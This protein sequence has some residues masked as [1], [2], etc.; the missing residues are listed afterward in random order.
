MIEVFAGIGKEKLTVQCAI[1]KAVDS[2]I[3]RY[4]PGGEN[5]MIDYH[6]LM[7]ALNGSPMHESRQFTLKCSNGDVINGPFLRMW[8]CGTSSIVRPDGQFV[9]D[10]ADVAVIAFAQMH[11][12]NHACSNNLERLAS[13]LDLLFTLLYD[14]MINM[15]RKSWV[16]LHL[17]L[18]RILRIVRCEA[19]QGLFPVEHPEVEWRS[20]AF[21]DQFGRDVSVFSQLVGVPASSKFDLT[22]V[23]TR[24]PVEMV[25]GD[26]SALSVS[27]SV[28]D[29]LETQFYSKDLT[30]FDHVY[31]LLPT[32]IPLE[33]ARHEDLVVVACKH[34]N[35]HFDKD[36]SATVST[37]DR[38]TVC[39]KVVHQLLTSVG[40]NAEQ[41][42][43]Q[44]AVNNLSD[45]IARTEEKQLP[46]LWSEGRKKTP[47][48]FLISPEKMGECPIVLCDGE[49]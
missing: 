47:Q 18:E 5:C 48:D 7:F 1:Q 34:F 29:L 24:P 14:M 26:L 31:F 13:E 23:F 6:A 4:G 32:H 41:I 12:N 22:R 49:E 27:T 30:C 8:Y 36:K 20:A 33:T 46:L 37:R 39:R 40:W 15:T 11:L 45:L 10:F 25:C 44:Y 38:V 28:A 17:K 35:P 19:S 43:F 3:K 21:I 9:V 16:S 2:Y 42:V